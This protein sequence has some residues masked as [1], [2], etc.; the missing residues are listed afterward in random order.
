MSQMKHKTNIHIHT[1]SHT[2]L[3]CT[4]AWKHTHKTT[5]YLVQ[6]MK[7]S[8]MHRILFLRLLFFFIQHRQLDVSFRFC[9]QKLTKDESMNKRETNNKI[10]KRIRELMHSTT[11]ISKRFLIQM[12]KRT[13]KHT[14]KNTQT[15]WLTSSR[16]LFFFSYENYWGNPSNKFSSWV[17]GIFFLCLSVCV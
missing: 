2:L 7:I 6:S 13:D 14:V 10:L 17:I 8:V 16:I 1:N 5:Y 12:F 11:Q 15:S 9:C 3:T 4:H